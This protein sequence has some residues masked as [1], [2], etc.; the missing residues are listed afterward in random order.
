ML[1]QQFPLIIFHDGSQLLQISNHQQLHPAKW[2]LSIA[3]PPQ[4]CIHR[5]QQIGTH[6]T[7]LINNEQIHTTNYVP[8]FFTVTV[9]RLGRIKGSFRHERGKRQLKERM[10]RYSSRI[11]SCNPCRSQ[12]DH[13]FGR[14]FFQSSKKCRFPG[15]GFSGKK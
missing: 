2:F 15:S 1:P 14:M 5:I 12:Y 9:M 10:N 11:D 7:D 4:S 3:I 6:H 8:L 13:A